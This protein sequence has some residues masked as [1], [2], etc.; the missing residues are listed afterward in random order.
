MSIIKLIKAHVSSEIVL[1]KYSPT[2]ENIDFGFPH[3]LHFQADCNRN[4]A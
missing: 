2:M 1:L 4:A 3:N